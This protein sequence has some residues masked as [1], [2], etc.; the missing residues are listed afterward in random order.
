M[1]NGFVDGSICIIEEGIA[2]VDED[3]SIGFDMAAGVQ[4]QPDLRHGEGLFTTST[5][6][7][8]FYQHENG[9]WLYSLNWKIA[10]N[11]THLLKGQGQR[12]EL[13]NNQP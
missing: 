5:T 6:I 12:G 13:S 3:D 1:T 9:H 8:L 7:L 10:W 4:L 2:D 11:Y